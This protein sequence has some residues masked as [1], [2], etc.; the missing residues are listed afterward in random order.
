MQVNEE[1]IRQITSAVLN[2]MSQSDH[3]S[4]TSGVSSR[5]FRL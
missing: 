3:V 5:R 4:S 1:L 2:Q